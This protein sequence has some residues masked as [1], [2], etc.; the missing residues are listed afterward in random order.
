MTAAHCT[1]DLKVFDLAIGSRQHVH[2]TTRKVI[3]HPEY[4][5][6]SQEK[7]IALLELPKEVEMSRKFP[8]TLIQESFYPIL[9][10]LSV[11]DPIQIF[12]QKQKSPNN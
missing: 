11:F 4:N 3:K 5:Q 6:N 1:L 8:L 10:E 9:T 12:A 2:Q 7:D